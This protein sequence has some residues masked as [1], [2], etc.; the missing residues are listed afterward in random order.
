[1]GDISY[2]GEFYYQGGKSGLAFSV[3]TDGTAGDF[4]AYMFGIRVGYK[5]KNV[6]M[7]P[8]ATLW[9]DYLSGS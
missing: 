6:A 2:R 3:P 5:A 9:F 4:N 8:S 1:M 7:K